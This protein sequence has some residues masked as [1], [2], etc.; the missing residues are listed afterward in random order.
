M[1]TLSDFLELRGYR[2]VISVAIL[3]VACSVPENQDPKPSSEQAPSNPTT[4][5]ESPT[6]VGTFEPLDDS[7][8]PD[9]P[10]ENLTTGIREIDKL[11]TI[12]L[13]N[14]T[15][16]KVAQVQFSTAGCT[17]VMGLGGAP[18]CKEDQ[19]EG[20]LVD[21]VPVLGPGEGSTILPEKIVGLLDFQV[22]SIY[23]AYR[24]VNRPITDHYYA[25]GTYGLVFTTS[26]EEQA[27]QYI[28]VH[29]NDD[30]QI[31]RLDYLPWKPDELIEKEAGQLL[32]L[33]PEERESDGPD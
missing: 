8:P 15:E 25:P 18:K 4:V 22:E 1:N 17:K 21:Y 2:I 20:T 5:I 23:A 11:I 16:E 28:L 29:A 26:P 13:G 14:D 9:D 10:K 30:G 33:P 27:T 3:L 32:I 31:V 7:V 24:R 19:G 12:V 6:E